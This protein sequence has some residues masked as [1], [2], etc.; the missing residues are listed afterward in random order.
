[1][2]RRFFNWLFRRKRHW[3]E[4]EKDAILARATPG[5][6]WGEGDGARL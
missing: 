1:M 3:T 2:I 4:A 5:L 6:L